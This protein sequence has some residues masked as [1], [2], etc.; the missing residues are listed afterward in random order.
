MP[1]VVWNKS[2]G[3]GSG[4]SWLWFHIRFL[5]KISRKVGPG[6]KPQHCL[7][8]RLFYRYLTLCFCKFGFW[9]G[10]PLA[11]WWW[12]CSATTWWQLSA[13]R[14]WR[15]SAD[16]TRGIRL[17]SSRAMRSPDSSILSAIRVLRVWFLYT[18]KT[19]HRTSVPYSLDPHVFGP[20]G[21]GSFYQQANIVRKTFIPTVLWLLLDFLSLK[22]HRST[23]MWAYR[24]RIL[25]SASK[26]SQKN[27]HSYC[28]VAS[29]GL[30]IFEKSCKCTY[31]K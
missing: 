10:R 2:C 22:N 28:F 7:K 9:R 5:T 21:P 13:D 24:I 19:E 20:P 30:F 16:W 18:N 3:S 4:T 25:L 17:S 1:V 27:L 14:I 26:N 15:K 12:L 31:K 8:P 29:F 11:K 6:I 23:C